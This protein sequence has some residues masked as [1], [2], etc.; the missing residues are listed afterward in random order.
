MAARD[1]VEMADATAKSPDAGDY[2]DLLQTKHSDAFAFSRTEQL[3]L[4]LY[5]QLRELELE[6]S[7]IQAQQSG[8]NTLVVLVIVVDL[9]A[10]HVTD[11]SAPSDDELQDQLTIA[12]REVMEAKAEYEI[13]N[14]VNHNVLVMDP[15]LKAVHGGER[16][17]H[18]EKYDHFCLPHCYT[19]NNR[20]M[21]PMIIENDTVSMLHGSISAKLVST[22]RAFSTAAQANIMASRKNRELSATMLALAE[23]MKAQ[24][25]KDIEDPRLR[26]K[27]S[28]VEKDLKDSRRKAKTL[29]GVLSAMIVG[30]GINW[31]ADETL[32]ELVMDDEEG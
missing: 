3:A 7:L 21:L 32:T 1:D 23:E 9:V 8:M 28:A 13:R 4:D 27:V 12:Q 10:A 19:N 14:R 2:A 5:D 18:A 22:Q 24:T 11:L 25:A 26:E 17:G 6:Q 29:K 31:A 30:S 15:V 20:R 16:T